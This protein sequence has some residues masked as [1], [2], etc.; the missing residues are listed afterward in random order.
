MLQG[1]GNSA[2]VMPTRLG[3][4]IAAYD[5]HNL[6]VRLL[7]H[8]RDPSL[9]RG[10]L[11]SYTYNDFDLDSNRRAGTS[12]NGLIRVLVDAA[13]HGA[14]MKFITDDPFI[15]QNPNGNWI[16]VWHQHLTDLNAVGVEIRICPSL[17]AKTYLFEMGDRTFFAVGSSNRNLHQP[18]LDE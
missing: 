11:I 16:K 12:P 6:R 1:P 4:R 7:A 18:F 10:V 5:G 14:Q 9:T 17:H 15:G 13:I 2:M 8:L 3:P